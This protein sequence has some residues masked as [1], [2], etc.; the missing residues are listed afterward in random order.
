MEKKSDVVRN[1]VNGMSEYRDREQ[2]YEYWTTSSFEEDAIDYLNK[3]KNSVKKYKIEFYDLVEITKIV[4]DEK[5]SSI[6]KI[7]N[8]HYEGY[9]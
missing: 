8:E 4:R 2:I 9:E 6:N 3:I 1:W 7:L 5:L